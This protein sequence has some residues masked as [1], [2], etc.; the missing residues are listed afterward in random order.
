MS[1]YIARGTYGCVIGPNLNCDGTFGNSKYITKFFFDKRDFEIEKEF[2]LTLQKIDKKYSFTTQ[3]I[4]SCEVHLTDEIKS[5]IHNIKLCE[6]KSDD[7]YQITYENGGVN[8]FSLFKN[9]ENRFYSFKIINF[10]KKFVNIFEGLCQINKNKLIHFD[11]RLENILYNI[12]T[13]KFKIIDFGL[14]IK[15]EEYF[16]YI[17][18]N[19]I[20]HES[21][22]SDINLLSYIHKG[23][24]HDNLKKY[25]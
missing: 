4:S 21:Y 15:Q 16:K 20:H 6:L 11:I 19:D 1:V 10:L 9:K 3:M 22:P 24:I 12:N 17:L 2:E 14:M 5:K 8:L 18:E 13:N 23:I 25:P 7:V